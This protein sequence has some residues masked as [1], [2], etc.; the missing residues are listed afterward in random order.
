MVVTGQLDCTEED[1]P[2][3]DA[4]LP[5]SVPAPQEGGIMGFRS[6]KAKLPCPGFSINNPFWRPCP[7]STCSSPEEARQGKRGVRR[8]PAPGRQPLGTGMPCLLLDRLQEPLVY[9][10]PMRPQEGQEGISGRGVP[11]WGKPLG[12]RSCQDCTSPVG[13]PS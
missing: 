12:T 6:A 2:W 10:P 5:T 8:H 9:L 7:K 11:A 1:P 4:A 3:G 13:R